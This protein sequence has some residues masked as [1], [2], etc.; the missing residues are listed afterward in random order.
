MDF[1]IGQGRDIHRFGPG[2][3]IMLGGV[4]VPHDQGIQ[5]HS[6]GDV[7]LHALCDALL[8]AL[9][10]GDIGGWFP[11]TDAEWAGA[12]S[13][14]LLTAVYQRVRERGYRLNNLDVTVLAQAPRVAPHVPAMREHIA[15]VLEVPVDAVSIK[16]TTTE[17]LGGIGRREGLAA[18]AVVLLHDGA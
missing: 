13:T 11:D 3:H 1:R 5:A 10:L 17:G 8:G 16:A 4:R 18:E 12:D 6:D 7:V 9:A 2:D 14:Q 15:A